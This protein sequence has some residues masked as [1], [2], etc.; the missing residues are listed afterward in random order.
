MATWLMRNVV[1]GM[2]G[3]PEHDVLSFYQ[4]PV[5]PAVDV[6]LMGWARGDNPMIDFSSS[7]EQRPHVAL[8]ERPVG[9]GGGYTIA[10]S[11]HDLVG[12]SAGSVG[13]SPLA[14]AAGVAW[15]FGLKVESVPVR[16]AHE[17]RIIE[18][19]YDVVARCLDVE[20]KAPVGMVVMTVAHTRTL[21]GA[22]AK[23]WSDS[24]IPVQTPLG[25]IPVPARLHLADEDRLGALCVNGHAEVVPG[26]VARLQDRLSRR[27]TNTKA[28]GYLAG[29]WGLEHALLPLPVQVRAARV[30]VILHI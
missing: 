19:L 5:Y 9:R 16:P 28:R 24:A 27:R 22:E 4:L 10:V 7:V 21:D 13:D 20:V 14:L 15:P 3:V 2:T 23:A 26:I 1:R 25:N 30:A 29:A 18:L 11:W 8:R 6:G 12:R 17:R